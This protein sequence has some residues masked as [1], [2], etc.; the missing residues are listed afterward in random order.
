[1]ANFNR[2]ILAGNL[3]HSPD[4]KFTQGGMAI[5]K[6]N[7]AVN[8]RV[9]KGDKWEDE[10]SY[11]DLVAFGKT[12]EAIAEHVGKGQSILIEGRLKQ[13]RWEKEGQKKSAVRVY[14]DTVQFLSPKKETTAGTPQGVADEDIPF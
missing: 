10:V 8:S 9:K 4:L 7:L 2:I 11:F 3:V 1:M 6:V 14:I 13:E 5:C 12:G